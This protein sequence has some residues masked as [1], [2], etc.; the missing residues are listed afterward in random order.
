MKTSK[1]E[2]AVLV[3]MFLLALLAV[4][5]AARAY[6]V[7]LNNTADA[8]IDSFDNNTAL[9]SAGIFRVEDGG[10]ETRV[11]WALL[12]WD[13]S[14]IPATD[15]VTD[16]TLRIQQL[17]TGVESVYVY[18]IQEGAW[19]ESTVTWNNWVGTET[20][21]LLGEMFNVPSTSGN[22]EY[23]T[24]NDPNLTAWVQSWV[25]GSQANYGLLFKWAGPPEAVGDTYLAREHSLWQS[26][27]TE[28]VIDAVP[29]PAT[30][31]L[32]LFGGLA[33]LRRRK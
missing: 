7:T 11:S 30:L 31:A 26:Y 24:F 19:D 27:P 25:D 1:A 9:G 20:I 28:L 21:V 22:R 23:T 32:L 10:P 15:V 14:S 18:G 12:G 5:G 33:L 3:G 17:D 4:G 16:V 29:E 6:T 8:E 13:L 2:Q